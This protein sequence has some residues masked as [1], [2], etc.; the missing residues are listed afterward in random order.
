MK[1]K[2]EENPDLIRAIRGFNCCA[3]L[4]LGPSDAH[5]IKT[6]KSGGPDTQWNLVSLCRQHHQELHVMANTEFANKYPLFKA[7]LEKK[8]WKFCE[9]RNKWVHDE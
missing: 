7:M 5:H 4:K 8:G 2:R 3:C 6:K 9:V 1:P